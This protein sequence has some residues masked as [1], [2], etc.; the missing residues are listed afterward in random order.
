MKPD[1]GKIK[2]VK[3][4]PIPKT[5]KNIKQFLGLIGYYRRFIKDFAK[6]SKPMTLILKK[7][8][9]FVWGAAAEAAFETLRNLI[10]SEPML[11]YPDFSKPFLVTTDASDYALGAV[12][13]QG[14]IGRDLP[15]SYA[16]R[17]LQ[18]AEIN[19]S[20]TE[21]EL[22]SIIF[23]VGHF[24]PYLYG[25]KFTLVADHRPLVWL[26]NAK[27]PTP[28]LLRWRIRLNEYDYGIRYKPVE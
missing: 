28:K 25:H 14:V 10:C 12:L 1:S 21:K 7:E 22:L 17:T 26:H 24:R 6:I 8:N 15:I 23:A 3:V 5:R 13:S 18:N 11:Q 9:P 20:T 2:A 27:D 19:Y 16:S 4:F